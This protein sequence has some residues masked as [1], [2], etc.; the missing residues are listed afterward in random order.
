MRLVGGEIDD[1]I[2]EA[3]G[4]LAQPIEISRGGQIRFLLVPPTG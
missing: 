2:I 1:P 4:S 3:R